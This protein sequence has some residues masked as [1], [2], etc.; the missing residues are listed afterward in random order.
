[1][2]TPPMTDQEVIEQCERI[3]KMESADRFSS[4]SILNLMYFKEL[5]NRF[6]TLSGR[7][8]KDVKSAFEILT[9]L[10]DHLD[11][12]GEKR[13]EYYEAYILLAMEQ[14]ADQF[15]PT[16][17]PAPSVEEIANC[18]MVALE[19]ANMDTY[20]NSTPYDRIFEALT[21]ILTPKK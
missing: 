4:L 8:G 1:M 3:I 20:I 7:Q 12:N 15:K 17:Q 10:H 13:S 16:A 14:Y 6:R 9:K 11:K 19:T 5:L 18:V 21:N 2:T